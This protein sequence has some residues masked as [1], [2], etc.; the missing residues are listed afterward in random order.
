MSGPWLS[1]VLPTAARRHAELFRTLESIRQ[2]SQDSIEVL[3]VADKF[4]A[5]DRQ[6]FDLLQP[7]VE[8][9]GVRWLEHDGGIN[10]YGQPQRTFGGQRASGEWVA[11]T[12]DDNILAKDALKTISLALH[13]EVHKRPLFFRVTTPW[14]DFVW[15]TPQLVLSNIDADCL[16]LPREIAAAVRWGLRYEGDFDAA[17][18][19]STL[20]NG[21]VA[22]RDETIAI[23]RPDQ[24]HIWWQ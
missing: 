22:W 15:K 23:A 7:E 18:E 24:E 5:G 3:V 6:R 17:V 11:Y 20:A 19:A 12:Q 2:Q 10:C 13:Q 8:A 4:G 9:F 1:I 21:D 16:V 14:R